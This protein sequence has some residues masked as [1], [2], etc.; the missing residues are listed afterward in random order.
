MQCHSVYRMG[1]LHFLF[2]FISFAKGISD[3]TDTRLVQCENERGITNSQDCREEQYAWCRES[4]HPSLNSVKCCLQTQG[5][6]MLIYSI[7]SACF[8]VRKWRPYQFKNITNHHHHNN[9]KTVVHLTWIIYYILYNANQGTSD[10][11]LYSM[12][13]WAFTG[14]LVQWF[15]PIPLVHVFYIISNIQGELASLCLY[16]L[17]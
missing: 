16:L 5:G 11:I 17:Y 1:Q 9:N 4:N 10:S 6:G 13:N 8:D 14:V 12:F 3:T 7:P 2:I 15:I